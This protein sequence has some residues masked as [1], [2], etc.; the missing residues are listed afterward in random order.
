MEIVKLKEKTDR[1]YSN[2]EKIEYSTHRTVSEP[3]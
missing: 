1:I 3:F 2:E